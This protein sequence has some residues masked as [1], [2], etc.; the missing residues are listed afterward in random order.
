MGKCWTCQSAGGWRGPHVTEVPD[1]ALIRDGGPRRPDAVTLGQAYETW[2]Q[3]VRDA[4]AV[5]RSR[6]GTVS[7]MPSALGLPPNQFPSLLRNPDPIEV[8][9]LYLIAT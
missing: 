8:P 6:N 2:P 3:I 4:A 5:N 7:L 9:I 1:E